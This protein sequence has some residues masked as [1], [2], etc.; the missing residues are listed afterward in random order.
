ME[1]KISQR[2]REILLVEDSPNDVKM[3]LLALGKS[4]RQKN[5]TTSMDGEHAMKFL[6]GLADGSRPDL[7][8]LDLNL[9]KKDGWQVLAECKTDALL[10]CIPI[11]VFTTSEAQEDVDR[12]YAL[13]ANSYVTKPFDLDAFENAVGIIED[14]WLGLS[15]PWVQG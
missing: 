12:C 6:G 10:K 11:V 1:P 8:I 2:A 5:V 14:F 9:P 7:I 15:T 13:G 4:G 3:V